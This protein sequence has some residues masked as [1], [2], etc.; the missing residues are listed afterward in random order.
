[1]LESRCSAFHRLVVCAAEA[2]ISAGKLTHV[3]AAIEICFTH[4]ADFSGLR[5]LD[6]TTE[7]LFLLD[8]E[9][10]EAM[11]KLKTAEEI[12]A[13]QLVL[14]ADLRQ[15]GRDFTIPGYFLSVQ[16]H[17]LEI[18]KAKLNSLLEA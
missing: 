18:A 3:V 15:K 6:A 8:P 17:D 9:I 16:Q 2:D 7:R 1:M 10:E 5:H 11:R 13:D 12:V 14:I 4:P